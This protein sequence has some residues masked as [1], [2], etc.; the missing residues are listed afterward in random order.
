[1]KSHPV[2]SKNSWQKNQS[3]FLRS[4]IRGRQAAYQKMQSILSGHGASLSPFLNVVQRL[5]DVGL[6]LPSSVMDH[7][8]TYF[9]NAFSIRG[10]GL[11]DPVPCRNLNIASDL[12]IEQILLFVSREKIRAS[13]RIRQELHDL[14]HTFP[15]SQTF[16]GAL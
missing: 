5:K 2:Q 8:I 15:R 6:S 16:L 11:F 12:V 1:M 4:R 13:Q 14:L 10:E 7:C 9:A 3:T